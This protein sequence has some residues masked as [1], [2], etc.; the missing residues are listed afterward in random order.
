[1]GTDG[2][3]WQIPA[4]TDQWVQWHDETLTL[5]QGLIPVTAGPNAPE[6]AG[7]AAESAHGVGVAVASAYGV[8]T[9]GL[10]ELG[11]P[12]WRWHSDALSVNCRYTNDLLV[13]AGRDG[14]WLAATEGGVLVT[15]SAG[16]EWSTTSLAGVP[17]RTLCHA[18]GAFW[19]GADE[20]GVWRSPDGVG[21]TPAGIGLG[22]TPVYALAP[23]DDRLVAGTERGVALGDGEGTWALS[24]APLRVASVAVAADRWLAGACPGGLWSSED[25]GE[26]WRRTGSF[27]NVRVIATPEVE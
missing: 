17:V 15:E 8:A 3:L 13:D 6:A 23:S 21:W 22:H 1:V 7:V 11:A 24:G 27:D 12:R 26:T 2:G 19:A 9:G 10:D 4:G 14:R 16:S 25:S 5:V 20:G 18:H